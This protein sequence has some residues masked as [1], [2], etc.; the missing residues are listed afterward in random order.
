MDRKLAAELEACDERLLFAALLQRRGEFKACLEA[1]ARGELDHE[2]T[3]LSEDRVLAKDDTVD[4]RIDALVSVYLKH[5]FV[6]EQ[7]PIKMAIDG[8]VAAR[9]IS[10]MITATAARNI[11]RLTRMFSPT[12]PKFL[13]PPS[14]NAMLLDLKKVPWMKGG[15]SALFSSIQFEATVIRCNLA[16]WDQLCRRCCSPD[17][18][19]R[20][21]RR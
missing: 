17:S 12:S 5:G 2:E 3:D 15:F 4:S 18:A 19:V 10:K 20:V 21:C 16:S 14:N 7:E 9:S 8:L 1:Y 6:V 13:I 11:F